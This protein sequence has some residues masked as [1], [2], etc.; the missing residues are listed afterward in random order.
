MVFD[1][2]HNKYR[3]S[4]GLEFSLHYNKIEYP[5]KWVTLSNIPALNHFVYEN[6]N[7]EEILELLEFILEGINKWSNKELTHLYISSGNL[8][9]N[10]FNEDQVKCIKKII[11]RYY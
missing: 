8:E 11:N 7:K 9:D 6:L 2:I 1:I 4:L 3:V 10:G 5:H